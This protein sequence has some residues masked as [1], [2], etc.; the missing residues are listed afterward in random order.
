[1]R[2][3]TTPRCVLAL[4]AS[5][6]IACCT[7]IED[8]IQLFHYPELVLEKLGTI[9]GV[10]TGARHNACGFVPDRRQDVLR[11]PIKPSLHYTNVVCYLRRSNKFRYTSRS[12]T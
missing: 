12:T 9:A 6:C 8:S 1:M 2:L 10:G 11:H 4:I 7:F 3:Y 5:A